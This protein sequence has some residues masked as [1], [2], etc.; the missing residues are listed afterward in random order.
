[1]AGLRKIQK[2]TFGLLVHQISFFLRGSIKTGTI[3][4]KNGSCYWGKT[5]LF[6]VDRSILLSPFYLHIL[7]LASDSSFEWK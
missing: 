4:Q 2:W 1:M 6:V 7:A 5:P 3:F